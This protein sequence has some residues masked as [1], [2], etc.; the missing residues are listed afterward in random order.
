MLFCN[1]IGAHTII[2]FLVKDIF[3]FQINDESMYKNEIQ[4]IKWLNKGTLA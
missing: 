3:S 1:I 2:N 4:Q